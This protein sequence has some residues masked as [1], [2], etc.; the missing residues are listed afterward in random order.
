MKLWSEE[1]KLKI[2]QDNEKRE[3]T[4][5]KEIFVNISDNRIKTYKEPIKLNNKKMIQPD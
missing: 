2:S 4:D 3:A 5:C 1:T